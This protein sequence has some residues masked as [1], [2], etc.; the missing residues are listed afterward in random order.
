[1][2]LLTAADGE[3]VKSMQAIIADAALFNRTTEATRTLLVET[4]TKA[5]KEKLDKLKQRDVPKL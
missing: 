3:Y 1:M 4:A 2:I 5:E